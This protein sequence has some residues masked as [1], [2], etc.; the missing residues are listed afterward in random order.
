MN[1]QNRSKT[2]W[3]QNCQI[4]K[5]KRSKIQLSHII[6][7]FFEKVKLILSKNRNQD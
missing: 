2:S 6:F 4:E 7:N 1:V 3:G 5:L